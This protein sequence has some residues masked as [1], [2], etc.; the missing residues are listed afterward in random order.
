MDYWLK[1]KLIMTQAKW[2]V[3]LYLHAYRLANLLRVLFLTRLSSRASWWCVCLEQDS[4]LCEIPLSVVFFVCCHTS[5]TPPCCLFLHHKQENVKCI[6]LHKSTIKVSVQNLWTAQSFEDHL[7]W[8]PQWANLS[9]S[10]FFQ[11][12]HIHRVWLWSGTNGLHSVIY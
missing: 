4:S 10:F 8:Q 2:S 1:R 11:A 3:C 12:P 5:H 9:P 6:K 7:T